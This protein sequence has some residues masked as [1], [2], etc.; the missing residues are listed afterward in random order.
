M[1]LNLPTPKPEDKHEEL[2]KEAEDRHSKFANIGSAVAIAGILGASIATGPVVALAAT[3]L[4]LGGAL[5]GAV[6][7][8]KRLE[9]KLRKE[10]KD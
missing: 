2:A 5:G 3:G 6:N 9:D 10:K 1:S 7:Y 4:A 8:F